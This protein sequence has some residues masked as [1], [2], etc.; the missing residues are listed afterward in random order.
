METVACWLGHWM[1]DHTVSSSTSRP[2]FTHFT[3]LQSL[4]SDVVLETKV[5]V[6]S[7][8]FLTDGANL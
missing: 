2:C 8:S 3:F 5:R 4:A 6:G 7:F 1:S